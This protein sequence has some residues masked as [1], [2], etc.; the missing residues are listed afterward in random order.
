MNTTSCH[1][2]GSEDT[3]C[4]G[5]QEIGYSANGNE[6]KL[7]DYECNECGG[8]WGVTFELTPISRSND[9]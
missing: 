3:M 5:S 2:C 1:K 9:S 7:L 4:L 8:T 6:L